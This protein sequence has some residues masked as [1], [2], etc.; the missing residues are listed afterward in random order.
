MYA[1]ALA[2][3][4]PSALLDWNNNFAQDRNKCVCTHCGNYPKGFMQTTPEISTLDVLGT[5]LGHEDTFGAVKG[6]VAPGAFSFFRIST[7]DTAGCIK[8]YVGEGQITADAYGMDGGIAVTQVNNLQNLL[9]FI[10]KNGFE[11]HV[12]MGRGSLAD[13]IEEATVNYLDWEVYRHE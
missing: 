12:A 5:Q 4:T 8:A 1:L 3:G 13:V 2:S 9:K 11:H 7:D 6:K 10:C